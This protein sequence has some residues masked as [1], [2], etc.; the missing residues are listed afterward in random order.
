MMENTTLTDKQQELIEKTGVMLETKG[1][2]PAV[3]RIMALLLVDDS[4]ELTFDDIRNSLQL[5]KS[6]TSN[7]IQLLL[8]TGKI[9]YITKTGDRKR[10]FR[11][12][13]S[14][15]R[16]MIIAEHEKRKEMTALLKE[17]YEM[18]EDFK[19]KKLANNLKDIINYMDLLNE[20]FPKI[21]EKW[22]KMKKQ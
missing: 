7:G 13:I 15:F 16:D 19:N 6:A 18:R 2:Q 14:M 9:E 11:S 22:E 4:G 8:N 10:Y 5:S 17:I 3:A 21:L 1:W 20:E 12:R